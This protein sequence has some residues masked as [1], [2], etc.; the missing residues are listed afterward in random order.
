MYLLR[1]RITILQSQLDLTRELF[2][3]MPR[4]KASREFYLR[5]FVPLQDELGATIRA[6]DALVS[7]GPTQWWGLGATPA[8]RQSRRAWAR[9]FRWSKATA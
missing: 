3:A 8:K 2:L 9:P 5:E 7:A 6:Y 1:E 4:G